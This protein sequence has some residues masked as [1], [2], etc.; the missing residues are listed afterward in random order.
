MNINF[1][2]MVAALSTAD[3]LADA[4]ESLLAEVYR[5]QPR[6]AMLP[7]DC[8]VWTHLMA[9]REARRLEGL[10]GLSDREGS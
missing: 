2:A 6:S 7:R 3:R 5:D 1:P 9:Y 8:A 4:V 10:R